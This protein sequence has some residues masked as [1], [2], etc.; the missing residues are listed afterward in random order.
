MT[1]KIIWP[2]IPK[3]VR[4]AADS[5]L[6]SGKI[7]YWTGTQ[8]RDFEQEYAA[9]LGVP[10]AL[11]VANG[12]L[13]LEMALRA[14]GIGDNGR[15]DEV[16]VPSRTFIATAG[17]VVA[18]GATPIIADI[19]PRTNCLT[20]LSVA[21][22]T[23]PRTRAV[24]PVHLGGYPVD[25]DALISLVDQLDNVRVIED[26]A[27]AHGARYRGRAVGSIGDAGCYSFCQE[28]ILPLGEGGLLVFRDGTDA[29]AAY[30]RA[31]AYRD[32]GRSWGKAHDAGI[33][34]ASSRFRYM[35]DSFGTNARL[36][37]AQGA[38]GRVMLASHLPLWHEERT[39]NATILK[40]ELE[41]CAH[42]YTP[43]NTAQC[44]SLISFVDLSRGETA[45]ESEHAY[46]RLYA[47]LNLDVLREDWSRDRVID[48]INARAAEE[49]L[50]AGVVQ[51]GSS[52][53]IGLESAF[54][55]A[56]LVVPMHN[57]D[58]LAGAREADTRSLT[59]FVDPGRS[60]DDMRLAA[61]VARAV[62]KEA[63]D[64]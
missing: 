42:F 44:K 41:E 28:K 59:F 11:A 10:Y 27:Q 58:E 51:Y 63:V 48:E 32:H 23:T 3:D 30:E 13:A 54:A 6:A 26:C 56:G 21:K 35:N 4:E 62:L 43:S 31:W 64:A 33:S 18:V 34:A 16:I 50:T 45:R 40:E 61:Q 55:N 15:K 52:A 46:Y 2:C 1:K 12:T 36:T 49:G 7:N 53:L 14:Y 20:A 22:V 19:D 9:Y 57:A 5:V 37:E 25:M 39:R 24:I 8:C 29:R 60:A 17:A 38:M 47:L